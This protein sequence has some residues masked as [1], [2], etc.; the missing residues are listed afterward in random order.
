VQKNRAEARQIMQKRGYGSDKRLALKVSTRSIT[1]F[2]DPP[3]DR[4]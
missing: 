3:A 2:R 4:D 1:P